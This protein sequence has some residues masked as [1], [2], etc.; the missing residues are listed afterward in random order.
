MIVVIVQSSVPRCR[1]RVMRREMPVDRRV[2]VM[3]VALM[4]MLRRK[5]RPGADDGRQ[6]QNKRASHRSKHEA[7]IMVRRIGAVKRLL[8]T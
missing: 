8:V 3:V 5:R 7:A 4:D 1:L 2:R 6:E